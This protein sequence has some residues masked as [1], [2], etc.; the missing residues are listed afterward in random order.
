MSGKNILRILSVPT[1]LF[2]QKGPDVYLPL[3]NTAPIIG[4]DNVGTTGTLDNTFVGKQL[5]SIGVLAQYAE[6]SRIMS[7]EDGTGI[8]PTKSIGLAA[9]LSMADGATINQLR[10]A[11]AVTNNTSAT[12]IIIA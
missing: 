9:D 8:S 11:F 10:Q 7:V 1:V 3:G 4:T 2:T 5:Y 12:L 6:T